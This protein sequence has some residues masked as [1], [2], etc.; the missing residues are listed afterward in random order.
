MF[1]AVR[2]RKNF[3]TGGKAARTEKAFKYLFIAL[4]GN[5]HFAIS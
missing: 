5:E 3:S 2:V 4:G 1:I